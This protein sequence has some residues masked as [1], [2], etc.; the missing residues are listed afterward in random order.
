MNILAL[1]HV[2]FETPALI[3]EWAAARGHMLTVC[4]VDEAANL[5]TSDSFDML[6]IMGG[7]MG[8]H[9]VVEH[10]W[11]VAEKA[12]IK[13]AIDSGKY[14]LGVCLGAQLIADVLGA[15]V[16]PNH[17]KEI[18]WMPVAVPDAALGQPVLAGLNNAMTVFHWHG[19]TF[20]L[21]GGA[22]HLM[23]SDA[24]RNQAFIYQGKV[25][26]LQFHLEM[27][28]QGVH[29]LITHCGHELVESAT[30]HNAQKLQAGTKHIPAC[31]TV[32]F[33]LLD[34]LTS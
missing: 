1:Q 4:R 18:G 30:I 31:K 19:D 23:A 16:Y 17:V 22:V 8:V 11:L 12:L 26:G 7:P 15:K 10:P 13:S 34:N 2:A 5:P 28:E 27:T 25:L 32:L 21:P 6:V 29:A 9:D 14:V 24:C 33:R 3:A 20:E